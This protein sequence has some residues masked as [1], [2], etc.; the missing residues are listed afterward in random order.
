MNIDIPEVR[1][2]LAAIVVLLLALAAWAIRSQFRDG[3]P[4]FDGFRH[5]AD[6]L[7]PQ[8]THKPDGQR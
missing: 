2:A 1:Y 5:F 7:R 6:G 8:A 4:L 3:P